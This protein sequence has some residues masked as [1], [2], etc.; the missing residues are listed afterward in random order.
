MD[1]HPICYRKQV[2]VRQVCDA[3]NRLV[4][5]AQE[6]LRRHE[7]ISSIPQAAYSMR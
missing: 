5:S 7:E 6:V 4:Q 2:A 1:S 3:A